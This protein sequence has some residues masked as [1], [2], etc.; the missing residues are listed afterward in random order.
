MWRRRSSN[1]I[2]SVAEI[3]TRD[4]DPTGGS[5]SMTWKRL[6]A[7]INSG[8]GGLHR[9]GV[10]IRPVDF[11]RGESDFIVSS[12]RRRVNRAAWLFLVFLLSRLDE[13]AVAETD[14]IRIADKNNPA[15]PSVLPEEAHEISPACV[16]CGVRH[17][18]LSAPA[19]TPKATSPSFTSYNNICGDRALG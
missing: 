2:R 3:S 6:I 14:L 4:T 1:S 10:I 12:L 7:R 15:E 19:W 5:V 9:S 13:S 8:I 16:P 18:A 11:L 17:C